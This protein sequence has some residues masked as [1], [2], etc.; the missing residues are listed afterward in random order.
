MTFAEYS[1]TGAIAVDLSTQDATFTVEL[2]KG[3]RGIYVGGAGN[4]T[5][6]MKD[7]STVTLNNVVAGT[8]YP[9]QVIKVIRATTTATNLI[10]LV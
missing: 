8:V 9:L 1:A 2:G 3:V 7:K 10:A 6:Q 4:L 5:V